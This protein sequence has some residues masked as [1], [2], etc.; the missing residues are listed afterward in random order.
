MDGG[1]WTNDV[2]WVCGYQ[3]VLAPMQGTWTDYGTEL[4]RRASEAASSPA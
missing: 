2:S 1:S 4:A 3:N